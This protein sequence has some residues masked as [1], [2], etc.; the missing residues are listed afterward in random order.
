MSVPGAQSFFNV[1]TTYID[2][3][4]NRAVA[5]F[6]LIGGQNQYGSGTV[7]ISSNTNALADDSAYVI[8]TG[9]TF[10]SASICL[11]SGN[12][13]VHQIGPVK[14]SELLGLGGFGRYDHT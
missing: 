13:N 8:P 2:G 4:S 11:Q 3:D 1:S 14:N 9:A 5:P 10:A 7:F 6:M 12:G